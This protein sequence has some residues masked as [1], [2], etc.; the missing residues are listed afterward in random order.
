MNDGW[1]ER[2]RIA[3][4][5]RAEAAAARRAARLSEILPGGIAVSHDEATISLIGTRLRHRYVSQAILRQ[6]I[7]EGL[8]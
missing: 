8:K 6:L 5:R 4:A 3:A 2:A 7:R 1:E